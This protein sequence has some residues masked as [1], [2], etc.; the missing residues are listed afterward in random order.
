MKNVLL[1]VLHGGHLGG[2]IVTQGGHAL[3]AHLRMV[4]IE[5]CVHG[6]VVHRVGR[7]EGL[8]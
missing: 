6:H 2:N 7:H 8:N 3:E 1:H 5:S 4:W